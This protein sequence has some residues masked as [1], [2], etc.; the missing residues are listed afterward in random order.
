MREIFS[1][2]SLFVLMLCYLLNPSNLT[3][4]T[5]N[6]YHNFFFFFEFLLV[7]IITTITE[8]SITTTNVDYYKTV[9]CSEFLLPFLSFL[10][11]KFSIAIVLYLYVIIYKWLKQCATIWH[12]FCRISNYIFVW[13]YQWFLHFFMDSVSNISIFKVQILN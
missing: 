2:I 5:C 1:I 11:V 8:P 13:R 12:L 10:V 9:I 6:Y 3:Y 7:F 4:Y